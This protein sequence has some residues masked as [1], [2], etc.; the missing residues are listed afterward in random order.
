[1]KLVRLLQ[2]LIG[3]GRRALSDGRGQRLVFETVA[4]LRHG[5]ALKT[6]DLASR[7]L[8]LMKRLDLADLESGQVYRI[9]AVG[10]VVVV[11]YLGV[12]VLLHALL[13]RH[14]VQHLVRLGQVNAGSQDAPRVVAVGVQVWRLVE[15]VG[16]EGI[17]GLAVSPID[18][19]YQPLPRQSFFLHLL[20]LQELLEQKRQVLISFQ[21]LL[22][23]L[24]CALQLEK[25]LRGRAFDLLRG[26]LAPG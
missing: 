5:W 1:M 3:V 18:A 9:T 19:L 10:R 22:T 6:D 25:T 24:V 12:G 21:D 17:L 15:L 13:G 11:E 26:L 16:G 8:G 2:Q 23:V 20:A 7:P 4:A 14:G